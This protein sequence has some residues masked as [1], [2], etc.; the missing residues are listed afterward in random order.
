MNWYIALDWLDIAWEARWMRILLATGVIIA[1]F[2]AVSII[3][4]IARY[5]KELGR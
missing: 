2:M 4:G 1:I 3:A 5:K